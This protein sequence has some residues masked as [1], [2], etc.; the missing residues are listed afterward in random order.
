[1]SHKKVYINRRLAFYGA[2]G[3]SSQF[4]GNHWENQDWRAWLDG[5][6]SGALGHPEELFAR[7]L[8]KEGRILEAG[9][10][11]GQI[12]VALRARG[13]DAEG[14]E[15]SEKTVSMVKQ[16]LGECPIQVGDVR[17]LD[18]P[19]NHFSAYISLGVMEHF[20]QGPEP[21]LKE[22]YRVLRD[23]GYALISVPRIHSIRKVKTWLGFYSGAPAGDF[24]QYA[25]EGGDFEDILRKEG[26]SVEHRH[27]YG[28]VKGIKD[29]VALF[30][31]FYKRNRISPEMLDRIERSRLLN[32]L[33]S[34][35]VLF[36][37]RK[38]L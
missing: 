14:V 21:I 6:K 13:Y 34:H 9:C 12:V 27:Y 1:M 4:W 36:V 32:R 3:A 25:F 18:Y 11:L 37:A 30:N 8:P 19:D 22:A 29:E 31:F 38:R 28:S 23:S 10:G 15:F 24:Y 16:Y 7:Y 26:F 5:S 33:A 17:N 20:E 35:M 2:P